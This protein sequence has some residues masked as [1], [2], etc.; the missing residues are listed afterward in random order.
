MGRHTRRRICVRSMRSERIKAEYRAKW[1][2]IAYR[3]LQPYAWKPIVGGGRRMFSPYLK[4]GVIVL[5]APVSEYPT[6]ESFHAAIRFLRLEYR[7]EPTPSVR[8]QS[9]RNRQFEVTYGK[10]PDRSRWP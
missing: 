7:L 8:F 2:W 4:N 1:A 3:P 10:P 6:A 5:L 9:L